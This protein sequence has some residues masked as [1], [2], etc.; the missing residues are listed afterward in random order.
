MFPIYL[1]LPLDSHRTGFVYLCVNA[2]SVYICVY[3]CV[4]VCECTR[5]WMC[6]CVCDFTWILGGVLLTYKIVYHVLKP[7]SDVW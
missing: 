3:F 7:D 2:L 1:V 5:V 6:V 4:F